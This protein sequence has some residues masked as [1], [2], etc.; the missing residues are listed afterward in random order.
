[1]KVRKTILLSGL[2]FLTLA[3][4]AWFSGQDSNREKESCLVDGTSLLPI[5]RVSIQSASGEV[6]LF[7]SLCCARTWL[8]AHTETAAELN[9]GKGSITLVDE[10]SGIEMDAPLAYFVENNEYSR[11]EN[12]CRIHVFSDKQAAST[13]LRKTKGHEIP[14]YLAGLGGR[15]SWAT[16]FSL[17]DSQNNTISLSDFRGKIVFLRFL[18]LKN[19]FVKKDL[20]NLQIAQE[21]FENQG[22]T[23]L[24]VSVEDKKEDVVNLL[25]ELKIT[26]P[27]LLDLE[28]KVADN[29]QI[30]GFPTGFLLD[31]S[32]IVDSSS[33]GEVTADVLAPFLHSLR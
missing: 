31:P 5:S 21:R 3:I 29:Y 14:G 16:D 10:I 1:M 20:A 19:P 28:G 33:I 11:K 27:V 12:K 13:Y 22:F 8:D 32:G 24:A 17:P 7:C 6:S 9:E 25:K 4:L 30:T 18:S 15:L 2:F 26:F 23:V